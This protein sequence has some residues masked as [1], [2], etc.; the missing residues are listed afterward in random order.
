MSG[1]MRR[2]QDAVNAGA[3]PRRTPAGDAA[4]TLAVQVLRLAALLTAV[5]DAIARPAGQSTARWQVLAVL[6]NGSATVADVARALG[7]ARQS[8]QRI[9][10][11]LAEDELAE[12]VENP[13]HRRAKLVR[14][15]RRG[16]ATLRSIQ[17]AQRA[18]ADV[19]GAEV[20]EAALARANRTLER[21]AA[22]LATAPT[23]EG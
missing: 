8:V 2:R 3:R 14:L 4:S 18:W 20:G 9:A 21:V 10:D 15:T 23:P 16:A 17:G 13:D 12:F 5:G 22:A 7:L 19:L 1:T 6:E 11:I